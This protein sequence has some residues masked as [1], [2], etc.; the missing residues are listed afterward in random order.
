MEGLM[1]GALWGIADIFV[2]AISYAV[3]NS[4]TKSGIFSKRYFLKSFLIIICCF[5]LSFSYTGLDLSLRMSLFIK[6]CLP[7]LFGAYEARQK[8][9]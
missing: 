4:V 2:I 1:W 7:A 9:K 5:F 8:M 6:T 3:G